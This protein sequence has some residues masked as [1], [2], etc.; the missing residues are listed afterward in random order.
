MIFPKNVG[1]V[2]LFSLFGGQGS[3]VYEN[4]TSVR[5]S[6]KNV[7][8]PLL[9][10]KQLFRQELSQSRL[11]LY[12]TFF[13]WGRGEQWQIRVS[14]NLFYLHAVQLS[15]QNNFEQNAKLCWNALLLQ[16]LTRKF[17]LMELSFFQPWTYWYSMSTTK[18][19]NVLIRAYKL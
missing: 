19:L 5:E 14:H 6:M 17:K 10:G 7:W 2:S 4:K 16:V 11:L 3:L 9:G 18:N 13:W 1:F 12:T 15:M 8:Y